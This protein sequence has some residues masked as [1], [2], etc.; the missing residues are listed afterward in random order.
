MTLLLNPHECD[1]ELDD[2]RGLR[3]DDD[4]RG[5]GRGRD[6]GRRNGKPL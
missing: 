5:R 1:R 2:G 3:G 4:G 6:D